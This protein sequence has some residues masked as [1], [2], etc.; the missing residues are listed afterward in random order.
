MILCSADG[1]I[2]C[3]FREGTRILQ[4]SERIAGSRATADCEPRQVRK[5]A[6]VSE[7]GVCRGSTWLSFFIISG[8]DT[9]GLPRPG[10]E[11]AASAV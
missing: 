8:K 2:G 7:T 10:Q 11:M 1:V 5:E 4:H 3:S 9:C 6:A